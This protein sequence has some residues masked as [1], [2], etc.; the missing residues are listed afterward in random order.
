MT[1]PA[2]GTSIPPVEHSPTA[3]DLFLFSAAAWLAHRIHYDAPYTTDHDGHPG[4]LIHGPLQ[5]VYLVQTARRWLGSGARLV[6][7]SYRH[8]APGYLGDSLLCG[9]EVAE[10]DEREGTVT[11]NLWA[12]KS[13]GTRTTSGRARFAVAR[14]EP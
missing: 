13:D 8:H 12:D 5:G 1:L 7:L 10:I 6:E 9:G 4:L 14:R 3:V 2:A 11:I